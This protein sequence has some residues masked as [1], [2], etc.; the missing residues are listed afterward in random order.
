[1]TSRSNR[2]LT[3]VACLAATACSAN[4][5]PPAATTGKLESLTAGDRACYVELSDA[6]GK[7][8]EL[9]ATFE[10]CEQ[11]ALVGKPV[12]LTSRME[13]VSAESCQGDPECTQSEQVMLVVEMEAAK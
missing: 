1:M 6:A 5:P 11:T 4:P 13:S 2:W 3:L 12:K 9:M 7:K 10:V 8:Q